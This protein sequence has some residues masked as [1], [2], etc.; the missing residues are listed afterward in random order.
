MPFRSLRHEATPQ[1]GY[2]APDFNDV[3]SGYAYNGPGV[4]RHSG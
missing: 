3:D 2:M 1:A 4:F